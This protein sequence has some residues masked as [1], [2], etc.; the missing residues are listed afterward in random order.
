MRP[1]GDKLQIAILVAD[2]ASGEILASIGS[3]AYT[4]DTREGFVDMTQALRS[5]GSTL[6]PLVYGLAFDR[7]LIHPETILTDRPVDFDGYRPQNFDG[8]YRGEISAR[9]AL[10][11]SL[12]V[13]GYSFSSSHLPLE[14][15]QQQQD[16]RDGR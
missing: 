7:G 13:P 2:H 12:N 1:R 9:D 6:K 5:P 14:Q 11:L 10:R 4:A 8:A 16:D 3:S 15:Q